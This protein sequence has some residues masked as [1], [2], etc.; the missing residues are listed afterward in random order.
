MN[1]QNSPPTQSVRAFEIKAVSDEDRTFSGYASTFGEPPDFT[2]DVIERGSFRDTLAEWK[3][4]GRKL[5]LLDSHET[6]TIRSVIGYMI[7]AREDSHGLFTKFLVLPGRDGDEAL[8]RVR[9]GIV[10]G[11]SIGYMVG[12]EDHR[13]PTEAERKNGVRRV[14]TR[15][16]LREVSL[17]IAPAND[18]ARVT[19]K[20]EELSPLERVVRARQRIALHRI[21]SV[22]DK[23]PA[24]QEE[25][26]AVLNEI[27][28][29][30]S[31]IRGTL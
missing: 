28:A 7:E 1:Q 14:L 30:L 17:V 16:D 24:Y 25:Q 3:S 20:R 2:G 23:R 15:I 22:L 9:A 19:E 13:R 26:K 6:G 8:E 11:L 29:T 27:Q 18:R 31:R 4:S 10:D 12:P 5:P 21:G